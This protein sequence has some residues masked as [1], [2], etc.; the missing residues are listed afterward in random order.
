LVE[1]KIIE[2]KKETQSP[3]TYNKVYKVSKNLFTDIE[4]KILEIINLK[5]KTGTTLT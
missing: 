4:E 5:R 2:E 3:L 1:N